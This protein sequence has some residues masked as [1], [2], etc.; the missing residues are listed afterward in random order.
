MATEKLAA[1]LSPTLHKALS[2]P[3][4]LALLVGL[5]A[6]NCECTVGQI[7]TC[8]KVDLSVVSRHLKIL[9]DAGAVE[10]HRHGKQ[11]R[12]RVRSAHLAR[13]FRALA[14]ALDPALSDEL[15]GASCGDGL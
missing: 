5:A 11:V 3:N 1:L 14:D 4:R 12:Y 9:R 2:E 13:H 6:A 8:C 7:S 10:A 15:C